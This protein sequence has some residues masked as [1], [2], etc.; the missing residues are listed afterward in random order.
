MI[1]VSPAMMLSIFAFVVQLAVFIGVFKANQIWIKDKV[2]EVR[3]EYREDFKH[4]ENRIDE[5]H[6]MISNKK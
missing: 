2:A 5:L 6:K 3:K 4:L 1:D